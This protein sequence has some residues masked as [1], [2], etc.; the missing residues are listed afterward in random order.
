MTTITITITVPEDI[1]DQIQDIAED[2]IGRRLTKKELKDVCQIDGDL[3][4]ET[5]LAGVEEVIADFQ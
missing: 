4:E 3:L 5:L 2:S 1:I